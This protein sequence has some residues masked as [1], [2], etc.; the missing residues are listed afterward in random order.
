[1]SINQKDIM[2]N[3]E[4]TCFKGVEDPRKHSKNHKIENKLLGFRC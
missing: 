1:M 2:L 3:A 4:L